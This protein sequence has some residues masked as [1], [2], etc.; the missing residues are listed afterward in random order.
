MY[1]EDAQFLA[2]IKILLHVYIYF[3]TC[4]VEKNCILR[5]M[6]KTLLLNF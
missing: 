5:N 6:V 2:G 3:L 4:I 1:I